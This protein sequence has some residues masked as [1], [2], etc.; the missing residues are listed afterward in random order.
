MFGKIHH[1]SYLVEDLDAAIRSYVDMCQ[2]EKTGQGH[3]AGLHSCTVG[4]SHYRI[5]RGYH[6]PG[7]GKI[8]YFET[9]ALGCGRH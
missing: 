8:A 6:R 4:P 1:V 5:D 9:H 3:V 2:G 7:N